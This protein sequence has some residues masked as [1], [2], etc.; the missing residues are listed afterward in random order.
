M[1]KKVTGHIATGGSECRQSDKD[2]LLDLLG[3]TKKS[4]LSIHQDTSDTN[5]ARPDIDNSSSQKPPVLSEASP[6]KVA[7]MTSKIDAKANSQPSQISLSSQSASNHSSSKLSPVPLKGGSDRA[8]HARASYD[9]EKENSQESPKRGKHS[10]REA[11]HEALSSAGQPKQ[12]NSNIDLPNPKA[13]P[14]VDE[15][16]SGDLFKDLKRV[17][18]KY[19]RIP[20]AQQDILD[21]KES[22]FNPSAEPRNSY[23][24]MPAKVREDLIVFMNQKQDP[25]FRQ[26]SEETASESDGPESSIGSDD[27]G[28]E[29]SVE[30]GGDDLDSEDEQQSSDVDPEE[31]ESPIPWSPSPDPQQPKNI[32]LNIDSEPESNNI[33][34]HSSPA[35][36]DNGLGDAVDNVSEDAPPASSPVSLNRTHQREHSPPPKRRFPVVMS[37]SPAPEEELELDEL[38][39]VGDEVEDEVVDTEQVPNTSQD[40]PSTA[41]QNLRQVQVERTPD[42]KFLDNRHTLHRLNSL[43][44]PP[45]VTKGDPDSSHLEEVIPATC[46][47]TTPKCSTASSSDKSTNFMNISGSHNNRPSHLSDP[48]NIQTHT[49]E[50][51]TMNE[52]ILASQQIVSEAQNLQPQSNVSASSS[53]IRS[54]FPDQTMGQSG[55]KPMKHGASPHKPQPPNCALHS[56]PP[57][58]QMSASTKKHEPENITNHGVSASFAQSPKRRNKSIESPTRVPLKRRRHEP[59]LAA[60][61]REECDQRNTKEMARAARHRFTER[62]SAG[63]GG[64]SSMSNTPVTSGPNSSNA[65]TGPPQLSKPLAQPSLPSNP[66]AASPMQSIQSASRR[67]T[68]RQGSPLETTVQ[69]ENTTQLQS[70]TIEQINKTPATASSQVVPSFYTVFKAS[71]PEYTAGQ[72]DFTW[73]LVYIEWLE[74]R[75]TRLHPS[76]WDDFIRVVVSEYRDYA[77]KSRNSGHSDGQIKKGYDFYNDH[78]PAEQMRFKKGLIT[79]LPK[80]QEALSSLDSKDVERYRHDFDERRT[81]ATPIAVS[82]NNQVSGKSE[83][84]RAEASTEA[85]IQVVESPPHEKAPGPQRTPAEA[86]TNSPKVIE[87]SP[88][89]QSVASPELGSSSSRMSAPPK[90]PFFETFSQLPATKTKATSIAKSSPKE[91]SAKNDT[92]RSRRSLPWQQG[93]AS[94]PLNPASSSGTKR[95]RPATSPS[96]TARHKSLK[97]ST[98]ARPTSTREEILESSPPINRHQVHKSSPNA[99][100][101]SHH[102]EEQHGTPSSPILGTTRSTSHSSK[103]HTHKKSLPAPSSPFSLSSLR[104]SSKP[105]DGHNKVG[106]WLAQTPQPKVKK[107]S[108]FEQFLEK[109]LAKRRESGEFGI[110][111]RT[112]TPGRRFCTKPKER[113]GLD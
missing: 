73:S 62:L 107:T 64:P 60:I 35:V 51:E 96:P 89:H 50:V 95:K 54:T 32:S 29:E 103:P 17:P 72:R 83:P 45:R 110:G 1:Q 24:L 37:S 9:S 43:G 2:F 47:N 105:L 112:S 92:P 111:S 19:V 87:E 15:F 8:F 22:W 56:S 21:S 70:P 55:V 28:P 16:L 65:S 80:L 57:S 104:S 82:K 34:T 61:R 46:D 67:Q 18:R 14:L 75:G 106:N 23:A 12:Q 76:V 40:I 113:R 33:Q 10:S 49:V 99:R 38:H 59:A 26:K 77:R 31:A 97:S 74:K 66:A 102:S 69:I 101:P 25:K 90:R 58:G 91:A 100:P 42:V 48:E 7:A 78:V 27:E 71:Y 79:T 30:E 88:P 6:E 98:Q 109:T 93:P 53:P 4:N 44:A 5:S 36:Q 84:V 20:R 52:D 68:Q 13:A 85:P 39:A 63:M 94:S 11:E 41:V 108:R 86:S 81:V 3:Q